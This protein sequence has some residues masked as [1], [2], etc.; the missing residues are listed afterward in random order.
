MELD[1]KEKMEIEFWKNAPEENPTIFSVPNIINKFK[2]ADLFLEKLSRYATHFNGAASIL[3]VGGGQGWASA[4]TKHYHPN[5]TVTATDISPYA[6]EA[7]YQWEAIFKVAVDEKQSCKSYS[8]PLEAASFDLIFCFASAHHFVKHH[9]T[10]VELKRLLKPGGK[11]LYLHEPAC[12]TWLYTM[13]KKRVNKKR[14]QVP[15]DLLLYRRLKQLAEQEGMKTTIHFTPTTKN[16]SV[17]GTLYYAV[18]ARFP[19]LQGL[20]PCTIDVVMEKNA[21]HDENT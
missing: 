16:R 5:A 15:E 19:F 10:I 1:K 12:R 18:L 17:G 21:H 14:P 3:E 4:M 20:F 9:K 7:I 13:A 8:V 2:D 11:I 6:I